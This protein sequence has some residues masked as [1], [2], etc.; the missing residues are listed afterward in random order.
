[1]SLYSVT[2]GYVPR[3]TAGIPAPR[4]IRRLAHSAAPHRRSLRWAYAL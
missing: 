3:A 4:A 1:M 2:H